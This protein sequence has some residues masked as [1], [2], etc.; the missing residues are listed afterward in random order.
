MKKYT[1]GIGAS[2][3]LELRGYAGVRR[4]VQFTVKDCRLKR[5]VEYYDVEQREQGKEVQQIEDM[6]ASRL[7][8]LINFHCIE[9][10]SSGRAAD[11]PLTAAEVTE[12]YKTLTAD[13]ERRCRLA[14]YVLQA[15][16][17]YQE[18]QQKKRSA[19]IQAAKAEAE[20]DKTRAAMI[21]DQIRSHTA[22]LEEIKA[23][24]GIKDGDLTMAFDCPVCKDRGVLGNGEICACAKAREKEIR[25]FVAEELGA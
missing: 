9:K 18:T 25:A 16:K 3:V 23:G 12:Y 20:G 24:Y 2:W 22:R 15:S 8:Y 1:Y 4:L 14:H 5:G 10:L 6:S 19:E 7:H 11:Y 21:T 13:K 17:A